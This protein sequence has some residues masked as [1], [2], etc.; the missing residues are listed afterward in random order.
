MTYTQLIIEQAVANNWQA[1]ASGNNRLGKL[2]NV[3]KKKHLFG[4]FM[5][6]VLSL[7]MKGVGC[8]PPLCET[9][10]CIKDKYSL[11]HGLENTVLNCSLADEC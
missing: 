2:W 6:I 8:G 11:L 10:E 9:H 5:V 1:V 7:C 3:S 4:T